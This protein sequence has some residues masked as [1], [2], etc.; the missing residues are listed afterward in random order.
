MGF[1]DPSPVELPASIVAELP[2]SPGFPGVPQVAEPSGAKRRVRWEVVVGGLVAVCVV[3]AGVVLLLGGGSDDLTT[4]ARTPPPAPPSGA[5]AAV[6]LELAEPAD[7]GNQVTLSWSSS[8]DSVDYAVIV[9]PEGEPN[10]A[11]L[12]QRLHTLT[13]PVDPLRRYCFEVQATDSQNVYK[14]PPQSIRGA[15]CHR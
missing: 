9:A 10:R 7:H 15:T 1:D 13:V 3:A 8:S 11:I 12:A 5:A 14:S 4:V 2:G 6:T